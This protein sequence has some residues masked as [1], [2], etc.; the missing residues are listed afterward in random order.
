MK[1]SA[2]LNLATATVTVVVCSAVFVMVANCTN[3][4]RRIAN[5][6][7]DVLDEVCTVDDTP[8]SCL[9]KAAA[10]RNVVRLLDKEIHAQDIGA[11]TGPCTCAC[12]CLVE[13]KP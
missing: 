8:E 6:V 2:L 1:D 3:V 7:L 5:G 12:E 10:A 4:Q 9:E 13:E 11:E